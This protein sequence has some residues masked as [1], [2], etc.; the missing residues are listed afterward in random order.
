MTLNYYIIT[1]EIYFHNCD[2]KIIFM[3]MNWKIKNNY[4]KNHKNNI[5]PN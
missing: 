4:V 3:K 1:N 5:L 2:S